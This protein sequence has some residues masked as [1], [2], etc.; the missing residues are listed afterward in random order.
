MTPLEYFE[1]VV[2]CK[3]LNA[4]R[5]CANDMVPGVWHGVTFTRWSVYVDILGRSLDRELGVG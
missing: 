4:A 3:A 2:V 5:F 1:T